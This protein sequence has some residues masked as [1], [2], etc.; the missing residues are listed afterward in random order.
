M[1]RRLLLIPFFLFLFSRHTKAQDKDCEQTLIQADAEFNSGRFY[2]IPSL[3]KSCL[4]RG[5]T[6]EQKV[7]AYLILT[8]AYLILD[9]P[10]A[11]DDS[12]LKLL[13]ADPEYVANPAR[14]PIDV[15][16]LSKKFTST[17]V[18]TPHL[19]A[20]FNTSRP[21][22]IQE[23]TTS[24]ASLD[25]REIFKVGFQLGVGFDWNINNNWS[26]CAEGNFFYKAFKRE[27]K[28]YSINDVQEMSE[29][30][31]GFDIPLYVKYSDDSGK[32]RPFGYAGFAISMLTSSNVSLQF[33]NAT[34]SNPDV[35]DVGIKQTS[36]PDENVF[37]KRN[38]LNRSLVIG[39][40]AKYKIGRDFVY[41]DLRYMMGL[42]NLTKPDKNY[43]AEG[44]LFDPSITN[45]Q[46]LS[47]FFRLD[48]LSLS[49]GYIHPIYNPRKKTKPRM[50]N[51]F[52][53]KAV[54][55]KRKS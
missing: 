55:E 7:R 27:S 54:T 38:F 28:G 21:R 15:Y 48:N 8:Q 3:L 51:L 43:Y 19:R 50:G 10:I 31:T 18:F 6:N 44:G 52:K 37:F 29:R 40:G 2:G 11:A 39:G 16:Y 20:G 45:Y 42:S 33:D 4:E 32:V 22:V 24:G 1:N 34:F 25:K 47:D 17:P 49:F 14:D 13:N 53:R 41:A 9:D 5:F 23:I 46:F 30:Q 12:Y 26:L 36:G 35:V